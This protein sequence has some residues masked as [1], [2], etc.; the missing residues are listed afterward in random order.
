MR[1]VSAIGNRKVRLLIVEGLSIILLLV[2]SLSVKVSPTVPAFSGS[3]GEIDPG[4]R[5]AS[6]FDFLWIKDDLA[7]EVLRLGFPMLRYAEVGRYDT[8]QSPLSLRIAGYFMGFTPR[9]ARD[10]AFAGFPGFLL[11]SRA[12]EASGAVS[13]LSNLEDDWGYTPVMFSLPP[14]EGAPLAATLSGG[15]LVGIYHTHATESYLPELGKTQ[16]AEAFSSNMSKTVVKI[17]EMLAAELETRYRIPV[18]HSRTVH[19]AETRVGAYYRSEQTVKAILDKYP[20][21]GYLV[22]VHRDSQPRSITAVTIRGKP[23]ARVLFVVGTD[24][25]GWVKNYEFSRKLS[26]KLEEAYP[27]ISRG[28]LYESAVYNQKYSPNAILVE[29]GGVG[30]TMEEC[31]NTVQALAWALASLMLPSAPPV[32]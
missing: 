24:N 30:N 4:L 6:V 19:D 22:D 15:P 27:G 7:K 23:Y 18:L 11:E 25:P 8:P 2:F 32:P 13:D 29:C 10:L 21:C 12:M 3:E 17:G 28:I 1:R 9:S 14:G 16:A 20:S 26:D 31:E 5:T